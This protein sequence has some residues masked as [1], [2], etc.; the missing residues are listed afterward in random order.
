MRR[1][2]QQQHPP[3]RKCLRTPLLRL[4]RRN[5]LDAIPQRPGP[6][7]HLL[8]LLRQ[9]PLNLLK[10]QAS[11]TA[12]AHPPA[13][14]V[15]DLRNEPIVRRIEHEIRIH[16]PMLRERVLDP[17]LLPTLTSA[18]AYPPTRLLRIPWNCHCG[19]SSSSAF[20]LFSSRRPATTSPSRVLR[21]QILVLKSPSRASSSITPART[22]SG[23]MEGWRAIAFDSV[24]GV[25]RASRT[26][27]K[28]ISG[29]AVCRWSMG[30]GEG[31]WLDVRGRGCRRGR[32]GGRGGR[33]SR[34]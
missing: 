9:R 25:V 1:I 7:Q 14:L 26:C 29:Y 6:W 13:P 8:E 23:K 16:E 12:I 33:R 30:E 24:P 27:G 15:R 20:S 32:G 17:L 31:G 21:K 18:P 34:R 5:P 3:L 10:A 28:C 19:S 4:I 2:P 22:D 11:R